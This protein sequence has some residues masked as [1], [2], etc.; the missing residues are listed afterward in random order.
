VSPLLS[1]VD[2]QSTYIHDKAAKS[3]PP[4]KETLIILRNTV[5]K[6]QL[7]ILPP[8]HLLASKWVHT[9][10]FRLFRPGVQSSET[11]YHIYFCWLRIGISAA[12]TWL[13]GWQV[14]WHHFHAHPHFA[15][16]QIPKPHCSWVLV[17]IEELGVVGSTP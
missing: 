5:Q 13:A 6:M 10:V 8:S 17:V 15:N 16:S 2:M 3:S 12:A 7:L 1:V 4:Q 14:P 11:K 9:T